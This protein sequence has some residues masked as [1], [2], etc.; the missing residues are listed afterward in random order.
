MPVKPRYVAEVAW[1]AD[2]FSDPTT[3][4]FTDLTP[5]LRGQATWRNGKQSPLARSETAQGRFQFDDRDRY[6]DPNNTGSGA[7]PYNGRGRRPLRIRGVAEFPGGAVS[8]AYGPAIMVSPGGPAWTT[9]AY[10]RLGESVGAAA[11]DETGHADGVSTSV[12]LGAVGIAYDNDAYT[13]NGASS[14][15]AIA[16]AAGWLRFTTDMSVEAW[17]KPTGTAVG[18]IFSCHINGPFQAYELFLDGTNRPHFKIYNAAGVASDCFPAAVTAPAGAWSHLVGTYAAGVMNLYVNGALVATLAAAGPIRAGVGGAYIGRTLFPAY[19]AGQIDEVALYNHELSA[20][21]VAEHYALPDLSS[22]DLHLGFFNRAARNRVGRDATALVETAGLLGVL[23][24]SRL[25]GSPVEAEILEGAPA[26]WWRLAEGDVTQPVGEQG[27]RYAGRYNGEPTFGAPCVPYSGLPGVGFFGDGNRRARIE[28]ISGLIPAYPFTVAGWFKADEPRPTAERALFFLSS[29]NA[30]GGGRCA[31]EML[32]NGLLGETFPDAFGGRIIAYV[33]DGAG[34]VRG[35]IST[36]TW[37]DGH[38]HF[39]VCRFDSASSFL[40]IIDGQLDVTAFPLAGSGS[41]A[42]PTLRTANFGNYPST[43]LGDFRS[44]STQADWQI[45]DEAFSI[46]NALAQYQA[47]MFGWDG[48]TTGARINRILDRQGIHAA[49]RIIDNGDT[50]CGPGLL[51]GGNPAEYLQTVNKTEAGNLYE[52][53][54]GRLRFRRRL[55][56][57]DSVSVVTFGNAGGA[58]VPYEKLVP[59]TGKDRLVNRARIGRQGGTVV[60]RASAV[61]IAENGERGVESTDLL[62][63]S[64][65]VS[66]DMADWLVLRYATQV[67][68]YESFTL[69]PDAGDEDM[70]YW[71]LATQLEDRVTLKDRPP[72]GGTVTQDV[73]LLGEAWTLTRGAAR[74]VWYLTKADTTEYFTLN[75]G[76]K[77]KLNGGYPLAF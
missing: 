63:R 10:Y 30:G 1:D 32:N 36:K 9:N 59:V 72:G 76:V 7:Y 66:R 70:T 11:A 60:E 64:D 61:S 25:P 77:G 3:W 43:P 69:A 33:N 56:L 28:D 48:D 45:Y 55:G 49:H 15:V 39:L 18:G 75:D 4:Q 40:L 38:A 22:F 68:E 19:Y 16:D 58:E 71:A 50:I 2:P 26:A 67:P 52:T 54:S 44:A 20:A 74:V 31:A 37:D 73:H 47:G 35:V 5:R 53:K 14:Q 46:D 8:D 21:R 62:M 51:T 27:G 23:G 12:T 57:I 65:N 29:D 42:L 17:V 13:F 24:E 41:P 34:T 6:F